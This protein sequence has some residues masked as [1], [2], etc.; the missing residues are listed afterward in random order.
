MVRNTIGFNALVHPLNTIL[1][2]LVFLFFST[3]A[4]SLSL[5][6]TADS[7]GCDLL[8]CS[9]SLSSSYPATQGR[10]DRLRNSI[11]MQPQ[12]QEEFEQRFLR[13]EP[14]E[15][16]R[17]WREGKPYADYTEDVLIAQGLDAVRYVVRIIR[18]PKQP[19]FHRWRAM[20]L[21]C[22]MDRLMRSSRAS[23]ATS[24]L[25]RKRST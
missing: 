1:C 14:A 10:T 13:L 21:L 19:I 2:A 17:I 15:Q 4:N 3:T 25:F 9:S 6:V 11:E 24:C 22:D 20:K 12:G 23:L 18:D 7:T 5:G 16:V 8:H